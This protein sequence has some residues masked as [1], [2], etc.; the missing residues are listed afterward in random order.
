DKGWERAIFI[1][2]GQPGYDAGTTA[3]AVAAASAGGTS[4]T[5]N[6]RTVNIINPLFQGSQQASVRALSQMEF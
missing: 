3:A 4:S 2:R 6:S 5:N 1:P